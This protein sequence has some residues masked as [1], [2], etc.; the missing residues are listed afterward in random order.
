ML[1]ADIEKNTTTAAKL[2]MGS[3]ALVA[4]WKPSGGY[5]LSCSLPVEVEDGGG[6][7]R[8]FVQAFEEDGVRYAYWVPWVYKYTSTSASEPPAKKAKLFH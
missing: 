5:G 8:N 3:G 2:T 6:G 7:G 1:K 4:D